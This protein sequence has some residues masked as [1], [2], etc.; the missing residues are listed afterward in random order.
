[1]L[2]TI[3]TGR[4]CIKIF[5]KNVG[6]GDGGEDGDEDGGNSTGMGVLYKEIIQSMMLYGS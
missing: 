6:D 4:P 5:G 2:T 1:M 3:V